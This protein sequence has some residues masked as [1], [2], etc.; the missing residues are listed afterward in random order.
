MRNNTKTTKKD[1]KKDVPAHT[2]KGHPFKRIKR[3]YIDTGLSEDVRRA[4][5]DLPSESLQ[6]LNTLLPIIT[7]WCACCLFGV[8]SELWRGDIGIHIRYFPAVES[9]LGS[10]SF[11]IGASLLFNL[12][13]KHQAR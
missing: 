9:I 11:V 3:Y 12:I 1:R 13:K 7:V 8:I 4:L 2:Y 5:I 6:M 10:L